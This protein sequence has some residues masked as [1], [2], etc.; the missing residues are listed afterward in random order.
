MAAAQQP[1]D[2]IEGAEGLVGH[3][4][5]K[6]IGGAEKGIAAAEAALKKATTDAEREAAK[7]DLAKWQADM[8]AGAQGAQWNRQA[9][10]DTAKA[11]EAEI[12][13][14]ANRPPRRRWPRRPANDAGGQDL[15]A[16]WMPFLSSDKLDAQLVKCVV[17]AEATPRGLAEFAQQGK[18]QEALVEKLLADTAL[19]KAMLAAGGAKGGKYG[20]AMEIYT[21]IQKASPKAKDGVLQRLALAA[22]LN[23]RCRSSRTTPSRRPMPRPRWTR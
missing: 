9:A 18:E 16:D 11:D 7:K 8:E 21:A 17:L 20:Q 12:Q 19:M 4:K 23:M 5:G 2:K 10:L 13:A 1:L 6:W 14:S 3:R 15:L 22:A